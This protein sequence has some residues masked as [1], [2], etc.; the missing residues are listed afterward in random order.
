MF[1]VN[2]LHGWLDVENEGVFNE[3]A[4]SEME[5]ETF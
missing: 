4:I 1:K 2:I 5:T 3:N